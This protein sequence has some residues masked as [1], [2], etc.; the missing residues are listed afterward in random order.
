MVSA[1][2]ALRLLSMTGQGEGRCE[3][4]GGGTIAVEIRAVNNRHLKIGLRT[5]DGLGG[6]ESAIEQLIRSRL[7][8][9]AVQANVFWSGKPGG[10]QY[11][12]QL[13][14]AQGYLRQ[15]QELSRQLGVDLTVRWSDLLGLPGM[16]VET[17]PPRD[18]STEL[19]TAVLD[20]VEQALR[21]LN[22]MRASEGAQM[23]AEMQQLLLRL[24]HLAEAIEQRAAG[25]GG[26][27]PAAE[28][29]GGGGLG[30]GGNGGVAIEQVRDADLI[31]EVA[32]M[33]DKADIRE[34]LVRLK[35]ILDN[36]MS[37]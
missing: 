19:A 1:G 6:L 25:A 34:E 8:R 30:R 26:V 4:S 2:E 10:D 35:A 7:R 12:I 14:V 23:A 21:E 3:Y 32:V 5:S 16:V 33:S 36:F 15:C 22:R 24:T 31:R 13:A 29:T 9:G 18:D 28:G 17:H 37:C 11:Q 20:A 27:S